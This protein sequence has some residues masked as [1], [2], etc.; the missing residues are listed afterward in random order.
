MELLNEIAKIK[1][2]MGINEV[3]FSFDENREGD[4]FLNKVKK[5][6][7]DVYSKIYNIYKNKGLDKAVEAYAQYDP[8]VLKKKEEDKNLEYKEMAKVRG[9]EMIN[10]MK[11]FLPNTDEIKNIVDKNFFD[12]NIRTRFKTFLLPQP[13]VKNLKIKYVNQSPRNFHIRYGFMSFKY[14]DGKEIDKSAENLIY[15]VDDDE[16]LDDIVKARKE[17]KYMQKTKKSFK[18]YELYHFN[19][20]FL[21]NTIVI[22][23]TIDINITRY[24]DKSDYISKDYFKTDIS[25]NFRIDLNEEYGYQENVFN[26]SKYK[27]IDGSGRENIEEGIKNILMDMRKNTNL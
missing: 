8:E 21:A 4:D 24:I 27:R 14:L 12:K 9:R 3:E 22:N 25:C 16:I 17:Y 10:K 18:P 13:S 15:G 1:K 7:P 11:S 26:R 6:T 23:L 2:M 5:N 19:D 20:Y